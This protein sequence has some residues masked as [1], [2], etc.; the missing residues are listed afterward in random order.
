MDSTCEA[1]LQK[2]YI[3]CALVITN[4]SILALSA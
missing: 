3:K 2:P 1:C 4:L